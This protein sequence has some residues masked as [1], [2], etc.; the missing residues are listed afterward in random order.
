MSHSIEYYQGMSTEQ[1][2]REMNHAHWTVDRQRARQVYEARMEEQRRRGQVSSSNLQRLNQNITSLTNQVNTL[3]STNANLRRI[4]ENQ[5]Q[6][7]VRM[8]QGVNQQITDLQREYSQ[9]VDRMQEEH[10]TAMRTLE[11]QMI[12][13]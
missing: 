2:I 3:S 1:L 4:I 13:K 6:N 8:Q 12:C 10:R 9:R 5:N 7:L 11:N